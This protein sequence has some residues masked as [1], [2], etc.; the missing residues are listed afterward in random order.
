MESQ[1]KEAMPSASFA[2]AVDE[3]SKQKMKLLTSVPHK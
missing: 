1:I 3:N 2:I